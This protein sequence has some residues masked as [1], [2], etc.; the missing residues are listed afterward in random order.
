[1]FESRLMQQVLGEHSPI[2]AQPP[3]MNKPK[4]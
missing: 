4:D 2:L 3:P 1:V